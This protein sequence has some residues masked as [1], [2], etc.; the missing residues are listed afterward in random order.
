MATLLPFSLA[1]LLCSLSPPQF[2]CFL[3]GTFFFPL[4]P[5][6]IPLPALQF[7][8]LPIECLSRRK[9]SRICQLN[10]I[11]ESIHARM[12][13]YQ[14]I[15]TRA[16]M[17]G[18]YQFVDTHTHTHTQKPPSS[19]MGNEITLAPRTHPHTSILRATQNSALTDRHGKIPANMPKHM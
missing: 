5:L 19:G 9:K 12:V 2:L 7:L 4:S 8:E 6:R 3:L 16:N 15:Y 11:L 10:G 1:L 18:L 17:Y 13:L 14:L